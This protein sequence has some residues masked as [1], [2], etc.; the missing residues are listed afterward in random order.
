MTSQNVGIINSLFLF[1][2]SMYSP[3]STSCVLFLHKTFSC[4][5]NGKVVNFIP[6]LN[7]KPKLASSSTSCKFLL[8]YQAGLEHLASPKP[9]RNKKYADWP[10]VR[11]GSDNDTVEK[12]NEHLIQFG[13]QADGQVRSAL[14]RLPITSRASGP[15]GV[16]YPLNLI[17][18]LAH[19]SKSHFF[20]SF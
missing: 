2:C 9:G 15:L 18:F 11:Q 16:S 4:N 8:V 10:S 14:V 17:L 6:N 19:L 12:H 20:Y 1:C 7:F 3:Y 5:Q 13:R